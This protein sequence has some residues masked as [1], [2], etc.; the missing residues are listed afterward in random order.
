MYVR[1]SWGNSSLNSDLC[2][3][4]GRDYLFLTLRIH[5]NYGILTGHT[6]TIDT[7]VFSPDGQSILTASYDYTARVWSLDGQLRFLLNG[8]KEYI[9]NASFSY[10]GQYIV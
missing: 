2:E 4:A 7:A 5:C 3:K 8:H 10:D 1:V 9:W 6:G